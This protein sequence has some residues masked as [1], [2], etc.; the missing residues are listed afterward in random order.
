MSTAESPAI[1]VPETSADRPATGRLTFLFSNF[2]LVIVVLLGLVSVATAYASFQAAL[3]DS[4][5]AGAYTKGQNARTTA[6]SLYLEANQQYIRDVDVWSSL[7]DLSIDMD[8]PD[9]ALAQTA[10][11]KFDTLYFQSVDDDLAAAI[12][13]SAEQNDAT[14][15][16][17]ASP[18]DSEDYLTARFAPSEEML[19]EADAMVAEGDAYNSYSDRLTLNTVLMALS[20]F[21]L[22][23]A[24]VVRGV[25]SQL[26]LTVV[27]TTIFILSVV[28]T[29]MIPFMAL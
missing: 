20:L 14:P 11:D 26:V 29:T 5:M 24:A 25:R 8:N 18:F 4:Q 16:E 10:S 27:A 6:E 13:W 9:A 19:A 23:I 21:L 1:V 7:T 17:Y 15:D 22:G 3:Y 28:L 2:E 12:T